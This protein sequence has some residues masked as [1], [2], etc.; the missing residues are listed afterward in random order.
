ERGPVLLVGRELE[1]KRRA[2]SAH[3]LMLFSG[4]RRTPREL[5]HPGILTCAADKPPGSFVT[6]LDRQVRNTS[7]TGTSTSGRCTGSSSVTVPAGSP[8]IVLFCA[9]CSGSVTVRRTSD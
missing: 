6:S 5:A 8:P 2:E 1:H 3:H 7:T 4:L 9:A